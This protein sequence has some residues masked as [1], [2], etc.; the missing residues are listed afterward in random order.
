[1]TLSFIRVPDLGC[2]RINKVYTI[3]DITR[4]T[5]S[6]VMCLGSLKFPTNS[7]TQDGFAFVKK[8]TPNKSIISITYSTL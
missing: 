5:I 1:M 6:I 4:E 8:Y 3:N 2:I 7:F